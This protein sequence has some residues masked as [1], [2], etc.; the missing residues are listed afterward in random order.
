M[1]KY[2]AIY[3]QKAYRFELYD[4]VRRLTRQQIQKETGC[5]ALIN[6]WL[7]A[8]TSQPKAG[9]KY[10][11]HQ[12]G[13][14]MLHGKWAYE[15]YDFPGICISKEGQ[16]S[17]GRK[18]N[19][20]WDYAACAQP[21]YLGGK[22]QSVP[23]YPRNGLTYTGLTAN[24]DVAVLVASKDTGMTGSEATDKLLDIGC[25]DILRWDGSWSSQGYL[26]PGMDI[27]PS[28]RRLVRGWLLIY[29]R[30][31]EKEDEAMGK[32]VC[33]DPGHGPGCVN[34]SPDG[35]YK[36]YEFAWDMSQ[37]VKSHLERHGVSVV[38][39][40]NETGYPSLT[41]RCSIANKAGVDLF[42]SL[43]SNASGDGKAWVSPSGFVIYTSAGPDTANRNVA[44]K[45]VIARAKTAGISILGSGLEHNIEYTVLAKTN[46][47][48][49]IV[50][51]GFH[52]N[53]ADT[54]LLKTD[55]YRQKLAEVDA[56]GILDYLGI[57]WKEDPATEPETPNTAPW[58]AGDQK[59]VVEHGI[60]D[61]TRPE[62]N[63]TRAEVWA[64]LH[65]LHY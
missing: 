24:G 59:W 13:G 15:K 46:A 47:P 52:T 51:H 30:N 61:G 31:E 9:V 18:G 4:N 17:T 25:I 35:S 7:F 8:L 60:S 42:V 10:W 12:N 45:A 62:D 11:D 63:V 44:A 33:L 50:E 65:R 27:Q 14:V 53:K 41:E 56:K 16:A 64:M 58:Y 32:K 36:E 20:V 21:E 29:K 34:G 23:T 39:T 26:G 22:K 38:M 55:A 48:A 57:Q 28:Q 37:K 1:S 43:H 40:K 3:P 2:L 49:M 54:A 5:Y 19:A 6:L